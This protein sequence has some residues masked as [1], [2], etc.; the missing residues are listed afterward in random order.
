MIYIE[1]KAD[2]LEFIKSNKLIK[3]LKPKN[4][5]LK[6]CLIDEMIKLL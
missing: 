1:K 6:K 2:N 5:K 4:I 3:L